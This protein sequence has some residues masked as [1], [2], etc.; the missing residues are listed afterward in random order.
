MRWLT[1]IVKPFK[2]AH[3]LGVLDGLGV[4]DVT[5]EEVRGYARQKGHFSLYQGSE[6]DI[7]FLPKV[8][9]SFSVADDLAEQAVARVCEAARTGRIGD[10]KI[11][12]TPLDQDPLV[13]PE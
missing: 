12:L 8:R 7:T 1:V 9:L 11:Y 10:G 5:L 4:E 6:Y 2:V 13:L 3:V